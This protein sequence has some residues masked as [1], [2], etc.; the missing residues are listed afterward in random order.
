M[1]HKNAEYFYRIE[2]Y[3]DEYKDNNGGTTPTIYEIA[4][5]VG[6]A[7]STISKYLTAMRKEGTIDKTGHRNIRTKQSRAEES[8][9][10]R[11]PVLGTVSCG[12]PKLAQENIEEYIRLPASL[13][14]TGPF[15][16]LH[17]NGNSMID[18]GICH[19]DLVLIRACTTAEYNQIVVALIDEEATL[20][21]YRPEKDRIV[22][23]PENA[24]YE[25]IVVSTCE[26]QGVAVKVFKDI[27]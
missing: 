15:F 12:I 9:M 3:I 18:A 7:P 16:L 4:R 20:K 14:G 26:I 11:V 22:L 21:R 10:V 25:D 23:H 27:L 5:S 17:A 13:F 2:A 19:G 8:S 24:A 6:L 1:Q